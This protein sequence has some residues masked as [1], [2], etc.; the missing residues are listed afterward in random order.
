MSI[1]EIV[2]AVDQATGR[3]HRIYKYKNGKCRRIQIKS[4]L[5]DQLSG[6]FLI[7]K[8]LRNCIAWAKEIDRLVPG[9]YKKKKMHIKSP[10]RDVYNIVK[11]LFVA[12]LTFY[13]KCYSK[14]EGRPVKLER[15]Q[16][17]EEFR[18]FHDDCIAYRHNFAAHSGAKK[19]E[20]VELAFVFPEKVKKGQ[21]PPHDLF[22]ELYQ[23]DYIV[24]AD[25]E[26]DLISLFEAAKSVA[27]KKIDFL[28]K[29][30]FE[31]EI[32]SRDFEFWKN[33]KSWPE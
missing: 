15:S 20:Y 7:E 23:P 28:I 4:R 19:I 2:E 25:E 3:V 9:E 26:V 10:D 11:G 31:D 12:C 8:D 24:T 17:G 33:I 18:D 16:L 21:V 22:K 6:Y 27:D 29:K 14:C 13:G 30:I 1:F 5:A 32:Y